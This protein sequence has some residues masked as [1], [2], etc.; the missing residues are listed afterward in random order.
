MK[1]HLKTIIQ[2]NGKIKFTIVG[3]D[4]HEQNI[5]VEIRAK[6]DS[7]NRD[8]FWKPGMTRRPLYVGKSIYLLTRARYAFYLKLGKI[9]S[10]PENEHLHTVCIYWNIYYRGQRYMIPMNT[11]G[12]YT[13]QREP[14]CPLWRKYR[15]RRIFLLTTGNVQTYMHKLGK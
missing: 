5:P 8:I 1:S 9:W 7:Y 12:S 10:I 13:T 4:G 15:E 3:A 11:I 2:T 6:I 14:T